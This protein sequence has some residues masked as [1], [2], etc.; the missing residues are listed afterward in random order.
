MSTTLT[1]AR[2]VRPGIV[3]LWVVQVLLA[4]SFVMAALP[5][6]TGDPAMVDMFNSVGAGQWLRYV[7]GT[8][9]LAGAI[10]LL[11]PRLCGPA[12]AGLTGLMVGATLTNVIL[13]GASPAIPVAYLLVAAVIV[14]FRR[15]SIR[16][17]ARR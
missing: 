10:G 11:L 13:L 16:E 15:A 8:L 9:E 17:L 2:R 4:A 7:T 3:A 12:A 6:L 14:W 5:K 1:T